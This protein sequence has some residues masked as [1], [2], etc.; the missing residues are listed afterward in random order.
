MNYIYAGHLGSIY[1]SGEMLDY[2]DLYCEQCGDSDSLVAEVD[3]V[4]DLLDAIYTLKTFYYYSNEY[5][6]EFVDENYPELNI[7]IPPDILPERD[8]QLT[9]CRERPIFCN[10]FADNCEY[11]ESLDDPAAECD[12]CD[13]NFEYELY[14]LNKKLK[15]D[16]ILN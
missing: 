9:G 7:Y 15:L 10:H 12:W 5:I 3:T 13:K 8:W 11:Y 1:T 16:E 2:N 14:R 6:K 4:E